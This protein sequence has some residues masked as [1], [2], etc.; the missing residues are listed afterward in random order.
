MASRKEQREQAREERRRQEAAKQASERR[1]RLVRLGSAALFGAVVVVA[2][3]IVISQSGGD[4]G[5][6]TALEDVAQVNSELRG[7]DQQGLTLGDPKAKVTVVEY[8][9]LQ[10]PA[11]QAYSEQIIPEVIAG[12]VRKGDAKLEFR[13]WTIIGPQSAVAAK[14]ALSASE[15]DRYW[16]FVTLFYRNQGVENSG[17]VTDSFLEAVARGAGVEDIEKWKQD[18]QSPRWDAVLRQTSAE[19]QRAGFSST[20]SFVVEGPNGTKPLPSAGSASAIEAAIDSVS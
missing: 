4:S 1:Q 3:A 16:S 6:D 18:L 19:A 17:Y 9:D 7:L 12:P 13:N 8:G 5:G 11:C 20:P 2:A 14:G 10:C 15:Q